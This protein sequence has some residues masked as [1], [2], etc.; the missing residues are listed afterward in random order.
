MRA[1]MLL[2]ETKSVRLV[3]S[4]SLCQYSRAEKLDHYSFATNIVGIFFWYKYC[5]ERS[6][7]IHVSKI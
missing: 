7:P 6:K 3:L 5:M 1:S 4:T 2:N